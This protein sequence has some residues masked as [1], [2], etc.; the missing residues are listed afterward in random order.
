MPGTKLSNQARDASRLYHS[1]AFV[2][3]V[4]LA[5]PQFLGAKVQWVLAD[6]TIAYHVRHPLQNANG[7]SH[8]ARGRGV[9]QAGE[10]DFQIAV[11]VKTFE[12]GNKA[13]DRHM[14]KVARGEQFPSIVVR[15]HFSEAAL[16]ST[17]IQT[18]LNVRFAGQSIGYRQVLFRTVTKGNDTE[19]T[20]TIPIKLT[21]FRVKPPE[22]LGIPIKDRVIVNV[23]ASWHRV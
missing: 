16:P 12:S 2:I 9:C 17:I 18:D 22:F 14:V 23:K 10:C 19:I 3:F 1:T 11:L 20:G 5:L 6:S 4:L 15:F 21:D 13:R 7:I 8:S